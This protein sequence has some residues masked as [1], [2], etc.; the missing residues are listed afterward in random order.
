M[1]FWNVYPHFRNSQ[2]ESR[3][4]DP[5]Q[6]SQ[7]CAKLP[8]AFLQKSTGNSYEGRPI[9]HIVWGTGPEKI[10]IWSQMHGNEPT[11]TMAISDFFGLLIRGE[12]ED[13]PGHSL[14]NDWK[15][16]FSLHFIPMLNPDGS[17]RFERRN[18][19]GIDINRDAVAQR[20]P[21]SAFFWSLIE[22]EQPNFGFN[23]H[24]QRSMYSAGFSESPAT[25]SLLAASPDKERTV[26]S[27]R[28]TSIL[29]AGFLAQTLR[30]HLGTHM[31]RYSDEFYPTAFG[32]NL[33]KKGVANVL[34]ESGASFNDPHR[35]QARRA[36]FVCL[37]AGLEAL[38]ANALNDFHEI[39]Y[40][41]LPENETRFFD[42]VLNEV[43]WKGKPSDV[44]LRTKE[45]WNGSALERTFEVVDIGD[46]QFAPR[47]QSFEAKGLTWEGNL[48]ID[49]APNITF[50]RPN[51]T[52][53]TLDRLGGTLI[54]ESE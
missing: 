21:E 4:I 6:W 42:L 54:H 35:D 52:D 48:E 40:K 14:I 41:S 30:N 19:E 13:H 27:S 46:L 18:A 26:N 45:V 44:G 17:K 22:K 33:Q 7:Y 11:A 8:A 34:I 36:N 38:R 51:A 47:F 39:H 53:L 12:R 15:K 32:D 16:A 1:D 37:A 43:L 25:I 20:S 9:H 23:L 49:K 2:F 10:F 3:Y 24:D 31:A 29:M 28:K 50:K 5:V